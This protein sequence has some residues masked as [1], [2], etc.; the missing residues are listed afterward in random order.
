MPA[1]GQAINAAFGQS[2]ARGARTRGPIMAMT[3]EERAK[4][5]EAARIQTVTMAKT[6]FA[7][8]LRCMGIAA[9]VGLLLMLGLCSILT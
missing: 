1:R 3:P 6:G 4:A 9:L 8:Y 5:E 2:E 7:M